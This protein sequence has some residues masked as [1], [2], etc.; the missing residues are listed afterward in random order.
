M[1]LLSIITKNKQLIITAPTEGIKDV[2][3]HYLFTNVPASPDEQVDEEKNWLPMNRTRALRNTTTYTA[4]LTTLMDN[5]RCFLFT[6]HRFIFT[7]G[8]HMDTEWTLHVWNAQGL[9]EY[10][11][12]TTLWA[13]YTTIS[14][15]ILLSGIVLYVGFP[16]MV[17]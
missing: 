8:K 7:T 6:R 16:K 11:A 4:N 17:K 15:I 12:Y 10:M 9:N 5:K 2:Q 13:L 1:L 3:V 14:C